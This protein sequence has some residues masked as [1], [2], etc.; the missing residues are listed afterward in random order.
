[1]KMKL[2]RI[3]KRDSLHILRLDNGVTNAI[4][5]ELLDDI[6][7]AVDEISPECRGLVLAGGEK[8]FSI[9]FDLPGLINRDKEYFSGFFTLFNTVCIKLMTLPVPTAAAIRGHA[10][11]GGTILATMCDSRFISAGKTL[12]GLNEVRLGI[13]VPYLAN[14]AFRQILGEANAFSLMLSGDFV[15]T[16]EALSS[17]LVDQVCSGETVEDRAVEHVSVLSALPAEAFASIK[18][19]KTSRIVSRYNAEK[20][21]YHEEMVRH[22]LM[23]STKELLARAAEKF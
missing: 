22:F 4:S 14:L 3:E 9:G 16:E 5:R 13:P 8:F 20:E 7:A 6:A 15:P 21:R 11:A 17:G 10:I 12:M 1:M 23:P 19:V 2:V 18:A